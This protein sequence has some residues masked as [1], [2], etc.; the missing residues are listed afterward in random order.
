M[1]SIEWNEDDSWKFLSILIYVKFPLYSLYVV[2]DE[3]ILY[4]LLTETENRIAKPKSV[5]FEKTNN[6][7]DDEMYE[8]TESE[9]TEKSSSTFFILSDIEILQVYKNF[10]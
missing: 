9:Y 10:A 3:V 7:S 1:D 2:V 8:Y 6:T 4:N 5:D